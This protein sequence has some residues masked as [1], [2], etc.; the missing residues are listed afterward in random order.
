MNSATTVTDLPELPQE[1][2]IT[3]EDN[4]KRQNEAGAEEG[5]D[6]AVIG[7]V[8]GVPVQGWRENASF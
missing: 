1:F 4:S 5:N 6:V 8:V 2:S 3:E 7:H